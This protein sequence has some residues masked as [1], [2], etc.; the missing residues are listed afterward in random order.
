MPENIVLR[1]ERK[2]R[3]TDLE[4]DRNF[5]YVANEFSSN[6]HYLKDMIVYY[7]ASGDPNP[8][9]YK[10]KQT[11]TP[12]PFNIAEWEPIGSTGSTGSINVSDGTNTNSIQTIEF[13]DS[14]FNISFSS[15]TA[16]IDVDVSGLNYWD[17]DNSS[18]TIYYD[19]PVHIGPLVSIEPSYDLKVVG[20]A[21][22][23][24]N[25]VINGTIDN[26]D[27][28]DLQTNY[29]AHTHT[30]VPTSLSGYGTLYPNAKD[31]LAD[32]NIDDNTLT[33]G[34]RIQWDDSSKRWVNVSASNIQ[35]HS[36]GSHS[37]VAN[38][39]TSNPQNNQII[40]YDSNNS[41]WAN[42]GI[43]KNNDTGLDSPF[44]HN[45]DLRYYT[46]TELAN[47][48]ATGIDIHWN[49]ITNT[50][51]LTEIGPDEANDG[52]PHYEDG[53]Y[54]D[55]TDTTRIGIPID[56]FNKV[57]DKLV[58]PDAPALSDTSF[59]LTGISGYM[60]FDTGTAPSGYTAADQSPNPVSSDNE[61]PVNVSNLRIGIFDDSSQNIT[62]I[63]ND[64]ITSGPG[65]PTSAYPADSFGDANLGTLTMTVNGTQV[66]QIDLTNESAQN[67]I[68]S[69]TGFDLTAAQDI[70]FS[71]GDSFEEKKYRTGNW[72]LNK[73][74]GNIVNGYNYVNITHSFSSTNR[75]IGRI[76]FFVDDY[77]Q[78]AAYSNEQFY[79]NTKGS[80]KYLSG[81]AFDTS[82][83]FG[84]N[85]D[86]DN[87]YK[88]SYNNAPDA[89]NHSV[90]TDSF[91]DLVNISDE[92]LPNSGGDP[93]KTVS[94]INKATTL[95]NSD[96]RL[97]NDS[98][99]V[100]T[101]VKRTIQNEVSSGGDSVGGLLVDNFGNQTTED[102]FENFDSEDYRLPI[103][104]YDTVNSVSGASWD[105]EQTIGSTSELQFINSQL[106]YP[107]NIGSIPVNFTTSNISNSP[108]YNNGGT[109]GGPRDYS[110][111]NGPKSFI[112]YF[113]QVSPTTANFTLNISG[114]NVNFVSTDTTLSGNDVHVEVKLPSETGWMDAYKDF[115]TGNFTDG[116]GARSATNG[117]GRAL[118]TDWG[119]TFG[120]K[121]TSQTSGYVLV[122][123]TVPDTF[124]GYIDEIDW[125]FE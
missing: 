124:A 107:G 23:T 15:G 38:S 33:D 6:R 73:T 110:G 106:I 20:D 70:Q 49:H 35:V 71:N 81:V 27:I 72:S 118:N 114:S 26:V 46:K 82:I 21:K 36:F 30:I 60:S 17:E 9:W 57:L 68:S 52:A 43:T 95:R 121:N 85:I 10:A 99:S 50:P 48:N 83:D 31:A 11:I 98:I 119:I 76:E 84:Y 112:R 45:H 94:I 91:G 78:V 1:T 19:N 37:D 123:I 55:F 104:N 105:S 102:T 5:L 16:V 13:N 24:G 86:I 62:G 12:G 58:P 67:N 89:I 125:T 8:G 4:L 115:V 39:I 3:L 18:S 92:A 40:L 100:T 101:S 42:V 7:Q 111:E 65:S 64:Q 117:S 108:T 80:L 96:V 88:N 113:R 116:D 59:G 109:K 61:F 56:R 93:N 32:F 54:N 63:L 22:I 2:R 29:N 53:L 44:D 51:S 34:D 79:I 90:S 120:T 28:S 41:N 103:A 77:T 25:I 74:D 47:G 97:L 14:N 87:A 75:V 122:K 69:G 66:S